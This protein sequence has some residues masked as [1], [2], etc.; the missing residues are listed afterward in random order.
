MFFY[1]NVIHPTIP[2]RINPYLKQK[3]KQK[4]KTKQNKKKNQKF[5]G[6]VKSVLQYSY[7]IKVKKKKKKKLK[8]II[9][10]HITA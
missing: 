2:S 9:P 10:F 4:N 6:T 8:T 7:K 1:S 3:T 5:I